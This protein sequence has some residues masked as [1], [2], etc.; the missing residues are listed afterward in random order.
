M[1]HTTFMHFPDVSL[2][3]STGVHYGFQCVH[4]AP[5]RWCRS[6]AGTGDVAYIGVAGA[7]TDV[8]FP[9]KVVLSRG[10]K[11]PVVRGQCMPVQYR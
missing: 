8:L 1:Q 2:N 4:T 3:L 7:G 10:L 6:T 11:E 5:L 9:C